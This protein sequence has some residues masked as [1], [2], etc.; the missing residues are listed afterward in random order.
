MSWEEGKVADLVAGG[1]KAHEA[2][3]GDG[4]EGESRRKGWANSSFALGRW[5]GSLVQPPNPPT[6]PPKPM[7]V[8]R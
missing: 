1:G 2:K 5:V 4:R 7:V 3:R 6:P 8:P